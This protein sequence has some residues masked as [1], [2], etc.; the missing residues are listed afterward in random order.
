MITPEK[1]GKILN[2]LPKEK[3]E[4]SKVELSLAGD[5][6]QALNT[7][8]GQ[9][10]KADPLEERMIKMD[11]RVRDL[12]DKFETMADQAE[13][14]QQDIFKN[15]DA[16]KVLLDRT[17]KA[18]KELGV[19]PVNIEGYSDFKELRGNAYF[20]GKRLGDGIFAAKSYK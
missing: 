19:S 12:I 4:L 11:D 9:V 16:G 1:F 3:T 6:K 7:L 15:T 8:R 10:K 14:L 5:I 18:A 17:E 13:K 20:S 2:K